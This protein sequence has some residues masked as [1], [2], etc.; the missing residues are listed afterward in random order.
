MTDMHT[1]MRT[2][3]CG[4]LRA[5]HA[6][7]DVT[8][9]G[10]VARR[11]DHGGVTFIDLRDREGV[12]QLVFHPEAAPEAHAAAQ[13]LRNEDV[14]RV[15]GSVRLR[16]EG[17]VNPALDT[18]EVEIPATTLEVLARSETPPFPIEDRIEVGED[19]RL[20][21]RYLDLRRPEMTKILRLRATISR[22]IREHMDAHGFIEV[23][24]PLLTR[25]TPEGSRD[26]LVPS[27]LLPGSFYALPQS[28]QQLKQLLMIAG[29]DRY[30]QI[31]RCLR[32]EDP[33]ADRGFEFT[34][35]DV[36]MSF[37]DED[38]LIALIEPLYA[39]IVRETQGV[40]VATPFPRMTFD[41][42]MTR[43]GSDKPD[44]RYGM[45]L[46]DLATVFAGTGFK[47]FA[48]V[49]ADGGVIKALAAPGAGS[50]SR[51]ELD[52]LVEDAKGRGA[53]GLVWIVV[54]ADGAVRSPVEKFL[55][56]EEISGLLDRTGAAEGD[57]VCIVADGAD[58]ANVALDGLRRDLASRL[59]LI[60]EGVW[61]FVWMTDPPLFEWSEEEGRWASAH[62]P[63]TS[64]K[65]DDLAPETAK[66]RGYDLV[67]NGFEI[68]GGSI[69]IHRPDVQQRVFG[70][71]GLSP[72]EQEDQ[73]GHLL[74]AFTFGAPPHGGI[75]MGL[76]RF[77][78]L[79]A[80]KETLRDV[81]AFPKAQS[82]ADP[83][84]GAP[85][86]ATQEQL[87]D[88]GL[89]LVAPPQ[90]AAPDPAGNAHT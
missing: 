66:S 77:T 7:E 16:P 10:W 52:K 87:R 73:F 82:G 40:D 80:G 6:G 64:P 3:A 49:A 25:S 43:F 67:L 65:T 45:E 26:F 71:L 89:R 18:G 1:A 50:F 34:Q 21:Y 14:V 62:H 11:R 86:P 70:V 30:Y 9:C 57:L 28:P 15:V 46:V 17:M 41:E 22:L 74:R 42:M 63:F 83:L 24:T 35:L 39:R 54:E 72:E 32:D 88:L 13:E 90:P 12:V 23:E 4:Q 20:R 85:A 68:G 44:L 58:R 78:M 36:E 19:L 5:S 33:R 29:Q 81:T 31:V 59:D 75:A 53:A 8:L 79:M 60:P 69:R 51:K 56:P 2:H 48:S 37:V 27:R 55:T 38:D 84:T 47:A 61:S 76:D